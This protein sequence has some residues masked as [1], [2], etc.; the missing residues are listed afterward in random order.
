MNSGLSATGLAA[1]ASPQLLGEQRGHWTLF[2]PLVRRFDQGMWGRGQL[3]PVALSIR[4]ARST[5]AV[6]GKTSAIA[7]TTEVSLT[8]WARVATETCGTH[9]PAA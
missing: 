1:A 7:F 4:A 2:R 8:P 5:W 9:C 6:K 3:W